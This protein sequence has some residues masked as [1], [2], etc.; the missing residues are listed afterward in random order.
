MVLGAVRLQYE[1]QKK[2]F[3]SLYKY[4]F[5]LSGLLLQK[6]KKKM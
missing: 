2:L 4:D 1:I 5:Y 3:L 6:K